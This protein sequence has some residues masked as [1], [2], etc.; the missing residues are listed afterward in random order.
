MN[1]TYQGTLAQQQQHRHDQRERIR[2]MVLTYKSLEETPAALLAW[3]ERLRKQKSFRRVMDMA[4]GRYVE[5]E[6]ECT[7]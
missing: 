3:E 4:T 7:N 2:R 6:A 5:G 1:T